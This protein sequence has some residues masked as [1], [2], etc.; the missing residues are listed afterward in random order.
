MWSDRDPEGRMGEAEDL[1]RRGGEQILEKLGIE[2]ADAL[3]VMGSGWK[4]AADALG[5]AS[6][7]IP[8]AGL[9]GFIPPTALGHGG[10]IRAVS[11][12]SGTILIYFGRTHL[13][14]GYGPLAVGHGVR[15]AVAAG[16]RTVVLTNACGGINPELEVGKPVLISDHINV[17][18]RTPLLGPRFIDMTYTY[19]PRLREQVRIANPEIREGV[20]AGWYGPAFETPSEIRMMERLGADMVG[21]STVIEAIAARA[22]G[23]EV[24]GISLVTNRAAGMA[25]KKLSGEEV[26]EIAT[27]A[28][29]RLRPLLATVVPLVIPK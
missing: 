13:Y 23:A 6:S 9:P 11:S 20:Y 8:M 3:F 25:G 24:L 26:V 15:A 5:P 2:G 18:G 14:E 16:V 1:A 19:S 27:A 29:P 12:P 21:M 4:E 22:A 7:E 28:I 17:T 10:T